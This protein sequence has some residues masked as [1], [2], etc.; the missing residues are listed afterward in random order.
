MKT[1]ILV[2]SIF[3]CI[4]VNANGIFPKHPLPVSQNSNVA[5][6]FSFVRGTQTGHGYNLQWK[7]TSTEG[8]KSF[9]IESTYEDPTDPYSVWQIKGVTLLTNGVNKF[10]DNSNL[11]PGIINYRITVVGNT[12]STLIVSN[13]FTTVIQ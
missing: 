5:I 13:I 7:L 9:I 3:T 2:I 12:N 8:V 1:V 11:Y 4:Q 6:S 10:S